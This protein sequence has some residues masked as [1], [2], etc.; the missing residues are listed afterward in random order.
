MSPP[1][2]ASDALKIAAIVDEY[3]DI[4]TAIWGYTTLVSAELAPWNHCQKDLDRIG[5]AV[6]RAA[7][8]TKR[9][10]EYT[11]RSSGRQFGGGG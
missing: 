1:S 8:V 10:A 11:D 4:L 3:N 5:V 9:L 7:E 6:K 2:R